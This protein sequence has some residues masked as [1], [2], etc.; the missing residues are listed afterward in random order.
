MIDI[1]QP[2][3]SVAV[4]DTE[5]NHNETLALHDAIVRPELLKGT[6][7]KIKPS[8]EIKAIYI[9]IN[10]FKLADGTIVPYEIFL[11]SR[12]NNNAQWVSALT[13]ILS[14]MFRKGGDI[15]FLIDELK[16]IHDPKGGHWHNRR[17]VPSVVAAVAI[18]LEQHI[19]KLKP[20]DVAPIPVSGDYPST[21]L[22]CDECG[23]KA[24]IKT[25]GCD[26]CLSCSYSKCG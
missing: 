21:A 22:V 6:T 14:A 8:T 24:L 18:V 7:Y 17:Y 16:D 20:A 5:N 1:D 2:I 19:T 10:D 13:V 12:D 3:V 11:N 9:T 4:V 25:D 23:E 15:K 26:T